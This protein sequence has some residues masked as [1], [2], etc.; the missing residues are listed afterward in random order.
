MIMKHFVMHILC[1][2]STDKIIALVDNT[3]AYEDE[4]CG[5]SLFLFVE[6]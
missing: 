2:Y 4:L 3:Y 1:L 6:S 5:Y